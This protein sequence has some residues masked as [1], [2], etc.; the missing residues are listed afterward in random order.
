MR[1]RSSAP[2][3]PP[4]RAPRLAL[5]R[6]VALQTASCFWDALAIAVDKQRVS[7][8][9][10]SLFIITRM[11]R[12]GSGGQRRVGRRDGCGR[13]NGSSG[14]VSQAAGGP[15][16]RRSSRAARSRRRVRLTHVCS[17]AKL[18]EAASTLGNAVVFRDVLVASTES[19][20]FRAGAIAL[21]PFWFATASCDR[22]TVHVHR[23]SA[24]LRAPS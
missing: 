18:T 14:A 20:P 8:L 4:A 22:I 23:P 19:E 3:G 12:P 2:P 5:G 1:P 24:T 7:H 15:Q 17:R 16:R 21:P 10:S 6:P 13:G 9:F 11:S